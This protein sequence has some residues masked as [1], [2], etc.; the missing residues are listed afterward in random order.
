M[1]DLSWKLGTTD[2]RR[3]MAGLIKGTLP[4]SHYACY[5]ITK[6]C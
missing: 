4:L 1:I 5:D 6:Y 2:T 3:M